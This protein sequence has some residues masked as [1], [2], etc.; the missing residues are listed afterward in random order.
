MAKLVRAPKYSPSSV[1]RMSAM[2]HQEELSSDVLFTDDDPGHTVDNESIYS[3]PSTTYSSISREVTFDPRSRQPIYRQYS[4]PIAD[5]NGSRNSSPGQTYNLD[6]FMPKDSTYQRYKARANTYSEDTLRRSKRRPKPI[7]YYSDNYTVPNKPKPAPRHKTWT[8]PTKDNMGAGASFQDSR[9]FHS[10][11]QLD[12]DDGASHICEHSDITGPARLPPAS[13]MLSKNQ[14]KVVLRPLAFRP[15]IPKSVSTSTNQP[16]QMTDGGTSLS[17]EGYSSNE[18]RCGMRPP[19]TGSHNPY[20]HVR[21]DSNKSKLSLDGEGNPRLCD[22]PESFNSS[23][24]SRM[25]SN[26]TEGF[27][28][29]PSPSDSGVSELEAVLREKDAEILHLRETMEQN[30]RAIIQVYEDKKMDWHLRMENLRRKCD[31]DLKSSHQK[32]GKTEQ[33]LLLQMF[34][35]QQE[36]KQLQEDN[37]KLLEENGC[38]E[39][40]C[41]TYE[42]DLV[43]SKSKLEETKWT[44][45]QKSG[46]ISLLKSQLKEAKEDLSGKQ[47]ETLVLK[48][49]V[50]DYQEALENKNRDIQSLEKE[51]FSSHKQLRQ[52]TEALDKLC[53]DI[54]PHRS[55]QEGA[56]QTDSCV[57]DKSEKDKGLLKRYEALKTEKEEQE[58]IFEHEKNQWLDEKNKVICYQKQLQLNYVQMYR[59]NK[60]LETEVEQ[61]MLDLERRDMKYGEDTV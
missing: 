51:V 60:M 27:L 56:S 47:N 11:G 39:N 4:E 22:R 10:N 20:G 45:Q 52:S 49:Q 6:D 33:S 18:Y 61:L 58:V 12:V 50:K 19:S 24:H 9:H 42:K 7:E 38:L 13:G 32:A 55:I 43:E 31:D 37:D 16:S 29:T 34:K 2:A 48:T 26:Q 3:Q 53:S 41:E 17:D 44:L 8:P 1:R 23:N 28:Q 35:L 30:E 36:R 40:K 54:K 5:L 25:S 15:V 14:K 59:K 57:L 21:R 46:E